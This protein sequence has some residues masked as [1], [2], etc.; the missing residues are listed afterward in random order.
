M[1]VHTYICVYLHVF[2]QLCMAALQKCMYVCTC[3]IMCTCVYINI[4]GT[5]QL[6]FHFYMCGNTR[7]F[8]CKICHGNKNFHKMIV[9]FPLDKT[10]HFHKT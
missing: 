10:W 6:Q 7:Y 9:A 1:Y 5:T 4:Y 8:M 3:I 2:I